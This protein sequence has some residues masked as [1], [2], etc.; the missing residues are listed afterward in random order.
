MFGF[1]MAQKPQRLLLQMPDPN[2]PGRWY[3]QKWKSLIVSLPSHGRRTEKNKTKAANTERQGKTAHC[4]GKRKART[5]PVSGTWATE[6]TFN[7]QS[8]EEERAKGTN[9][10]EWKER[11]T[12]KKKERR[13]KNKKDQSVT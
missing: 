12:D 1:A 6:S 10:T 2:R 7:C 13:K 5:L 4:C 8:G 11:K 9:R 3:H